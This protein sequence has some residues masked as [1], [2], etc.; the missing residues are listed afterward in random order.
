MH[1]PVDLGGAVSRM[2][3]EVRHLVGVGE[4]GGGVGKCGRKSVP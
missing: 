1:I 3:S 4:V 2:A